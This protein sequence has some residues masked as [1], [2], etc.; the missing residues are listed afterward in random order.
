MN[1]NQLKIIKIIDTTTILGRGG[2]DMK[3]ETGDKFKIVGNTD[4]EEIID[5]D[6]GESLGFLGEN[7]GTVIAETVYEKFTL[8]KSEMIPQHTVKG[9]GSLTTMRYIQRDHEVPAHREK[10]NV[11][12]DELSSTKENSEIKVGDYLVELLNEE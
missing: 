10:L 4:G 6:S 5:P 9:I 11:D 7:K 1:E 2:E 8:Y 12:L 3:I